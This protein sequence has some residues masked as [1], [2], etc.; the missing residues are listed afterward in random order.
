MPEFVEWMMG[1][2]IGWTFGS[3]T[4]RL[5]QL[6]NSVVPQCVLVPATYLAG[7]AHGE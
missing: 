7:V 2:E 6:G 1:Y 3:R 4:Q 5:K